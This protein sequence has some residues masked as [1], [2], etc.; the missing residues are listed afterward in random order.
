MDLK[1]GVDALT[2]DLH[3]SRDIC[4]KYKYNYSKL[5]RFWHQPWIKRPVPTVADTLQKPTISSGTYDRTQRKSPSG[6]VSAADSIVVSTDTSIPPLLREKREKLA[7]G[8][9]AAPSPQPYAGNSSDRS[10]ALDNSNGRL[11]S[12]PTPRDSILSCT[13]ALSSSDLHLDN[14]LEVVDSGFS[15]DLSYPPEILPLDM[16]VSPSQYVLLNDSH[17]DG[18]AEMPESEAW[19]DF[20]AE[21]TENFPPAAIAKRWFSQLDFERT[22]EGSLRMDTGY[23]TR[24]ATEPNELF[25]TNG[26]YQPNPS[27]CLG[28]QY[29]QEPL[30]STEFLN[31]CIQRYFAYFNP[32]FPVLHAPT[33]QPS[34]ENS[35]LLL[36][37]CAVGSM[38][39]GTAEAAQRGARVFERLNRAIHGSMARRAKIFGMENKPISLEGLEGPTLEAAWHAWARQEEIKRTALG[40]FVHDA[41]MSTL[42]HDEPMLRHRV[43][44]IPLAS[45]T[46]PFSARAVNKW[47]YLIK[48]DPNMASTPPRCSHMG[49]V[50]VT[51]DAIWM[52]EERCSHSMFTAYMLLEGISASICED[53]I[54]DQL[55]H[56]ASQR[57]ERDLM[58]WYSRYRRAMMERSDPLCLLVLWHAIWMSLLTDFRSLE[59]AIGDEGS[60]AASSAVASLM[61][62]WSLIT[63]ARRCLLHALLLQK[64]LESVP[65]GR[66]KAIHVP[67]CLFLAAVTW[68]GYLAYTNQD[69]H[70]T[71]DAMRGPLWP[72][73]ESLISWP[74]MQL[75]T[76]DVADCFESFGS[77]TGNLA[78]VKANTLCILVDLLRQLGH[79]GIA[80]KFIHVLTPLLHQAGG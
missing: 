42:L 35:M 13:A 26:T 77:Q 15:I 55:D 68:A 1:C 25:E 40:L 57:Y 48:R 62:R 14:P 58:S 49:G 32:A 47:A 36:S 3:C 6:V 53:R 11:V 37:V 76:S 61:P 20:L 27:C 60:T 8:P 71:D 39:I 46:D 23:M 74:E 19:F 54:M 56:A 72:S 30:P 9:R 69:G 24:S 59:L 73:A 70:D 75:L 50:T 78:F 16:D 10:S 22:D 52:L 41:E 29:S 31:L 34:L 67:R 51:A 17:V 65:M 21:P 64:R 38:F 45:C 5:L 63:D 66:A 2:H 12:R 80:Q 43:K 7:Y 18:I 33:F 28:S 4:R 79:C 44:T